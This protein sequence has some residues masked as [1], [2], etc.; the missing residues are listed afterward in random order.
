MKTTSANTKK[1]SSS[2]KTSSVKCPKSED[3][4]H[5]SVT[6]HHGGEFYRVFEEEIIYRGGT[7]TTV[8][9]IHVSN[10]NMDNIEKLLSRLGYKADCVRVWTKVLEIQDGFFLIR[11]DD[12]AVDETFQVTHSYNTHESKLVQ[13]GDFGLSR[14]KHKPISRLKREKARLNGWH[15]KFFVTNPQMKSSYSIPQL[16]SLSAL[17]SLEFRLHIYFFFSRKPGP[18][19]TVLESCCGNLQQKK[20]LGILSMQCSDPASRPTFQELLE[21]LKELQ[22]RYTIQFQAARSGGGEVTQKES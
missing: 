22:R 15:Q 20:F 13:V 14:I 16:L 6:L 18:T 5:F 7:D 2:V 11:K 8:N 9:G 1:R 21:R 4:Q 3:S 12:D 17:L 10:W 19:Y